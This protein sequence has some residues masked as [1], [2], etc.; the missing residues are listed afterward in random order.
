MENDNMS[1]P[2]KLK[3]DIMWANLD[4]RN[5]MSG[6]F[7]VDLCNLSPAAAQAIKDMGIDVKTKDDKGAYITCKSNNPIHAFDASGNPLQ[8]LSVGNGSKAVAVIGSYSWNFKNKEGVSPSLKKLVI[9]DLVSYEDGDAV[10][11]DDDDDIL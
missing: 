4:Q 3:A 8:G 2:I 9:T 5:E 1:A 6:K 11:V 10:S 7:Q